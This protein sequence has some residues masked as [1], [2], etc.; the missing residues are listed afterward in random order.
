ML[1][2]ELSDKTEKEKKNKRLGINQ[3]QLVIEMLGE[4]LILR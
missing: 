4:R 1:A 2:H 3:L